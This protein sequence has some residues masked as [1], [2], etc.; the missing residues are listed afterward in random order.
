MRKKNQ[1]IDARLLNKLNLV[2]Y[3]LGNVD[4]YVDH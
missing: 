4:I 1:S 3:L 2:K